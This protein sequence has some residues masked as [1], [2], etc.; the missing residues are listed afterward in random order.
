MTD[1][2]LHALW[3]RGASVAAIAKQAS[4]SGTAIKS[5]LVR[6]RR[7]EGEQRWPIHAATQHAKG[8]GNVWHKRKRAS[9]ST[10][11]PLPSLR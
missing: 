1:D 2:Q 6:L 7:K 3:L 4:C 10:L 9:T 8:S 11:P 5:R